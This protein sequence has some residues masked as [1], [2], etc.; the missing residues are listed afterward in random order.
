MAELILSPEEQQLPFANAN[1][2][3]LGQLVRQLLESN[4]ELEFF[5]AISIVG[6]ALNIGQHMVDTD[7]TS[8]SIDVTMVEGDQWHIEINQ[9]EGVQ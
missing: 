5:Q 8:A 6:A 2:E 4:L 3:L 9:V 7:A 1:A